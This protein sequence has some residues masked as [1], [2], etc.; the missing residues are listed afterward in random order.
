MLFLH[1]AA[2]NPLGANSKKEDKFEYSQALPSGL[3]GL[4]GTNRKNLFGGSKKYTGLS[5]PI[6][7]HI[8]ANKCQKSFLAYSNSAVSDSGIEKLCSEFN[9]IDCTDKEIIFT[10]IFEQFIEFARTP[11]DNAKDV[12]QLTVS[13][14][15]TSNNN[16]PEQTPNFTDGDDTLKAKPSQYSDYINKI[17]TEDKVF[18]ED[19]SLADIYI[20]TNGFYYNESTDS[21]VE[22]R[23]IEQQLIDWQAI[24]KRTTIYLQFQAH[25]EAENLLL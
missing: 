6:R 22:S 15:I 25:R 20:N 14:T 11:V 16:L 4:D 7:E 17:V 3:R 19:F 10:A 21:F 2:N 18:G 12:I 5:A 8:I 13:Q 24:T 1:C 9:I 23:D